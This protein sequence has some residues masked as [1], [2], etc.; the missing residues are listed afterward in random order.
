MPTCYLERDIELEQLESKGTPWYEIVNYL[1]VRWKSSLN[2]QDLLR[3]GVQCW[4]ELAF[5]DLEQQNNES[6]LYY[7][8][9]NYLAETLNYGLEHYN[10]HFIFLCLYGYLITLFPYY[11]SLT[12]D[13][14][15]DYQFGKDMI[16]KAHKLKPDDVLAAYLT[17]HGQDEPLKQQILILFPG[18][19][20]MDKYFKSVWG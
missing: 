3:L 17:N 7:K 2:L 5:S 6:Q 19:S 15:S 1:Y 16:S 9:E 13:Y 4:G 10:E 14:D 20:E 12:G 18:N 8:S 11:F